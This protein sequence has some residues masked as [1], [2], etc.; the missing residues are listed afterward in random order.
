MHTSLHPDYKADGM[1]TKFSF[2]TS[3]SKSSIGYS[4][5]CSKRKEGEEE[6]ERDQ[7]KKPEQERIL[8]N[9]NS[10]TNGTV[11]NDELKSANSIKVSQE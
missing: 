3:S 10:T 5:R 2:I 4:F 7:K 9:H 6:E 8:L 11:L 1:V